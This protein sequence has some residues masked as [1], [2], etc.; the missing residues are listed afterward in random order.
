MAASQAVNTENHIDFADAT[1]ESR[2]NATNPM[3][4]TKRTEQPKSWESS[5]DEHAKRFSAQSH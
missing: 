5:T 4:W 1:Q 3:L 2:G